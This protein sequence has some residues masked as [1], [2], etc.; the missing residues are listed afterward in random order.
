MAQIIAYTM[1]INAYTGEEGNLS[2]QHGSQLLAAAQIADT[3]DLVTIPAGSKLLDA[4]LV[5]AALGASVTVALGYRFKDGTTG[6]SAT[7][8]LAATAATS[9]AKT[10]SVFAPIVFAKDVVLYATIAGGAATGQI[11]VVT[12]YIF[13]GTL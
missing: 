11:D 7:A 5:N 2:A 3:V 13:Q 1:L 6:G 10:N 4:A 12:N 8:L 9:A